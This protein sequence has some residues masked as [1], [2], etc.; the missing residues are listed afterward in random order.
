MPWATYLGRITM[1]P[2]RHT[3]LFTLVLL[4]SLIVAQDDTTALDND[5][6]VTQA[7]VDSVEASYVY[8]TGRTVIADGAATLDLP[9]GYRFLDGDQARQVITDLWENPPEVAAPVIG[10]ILPPN[11]GIWD[12]G[13]TFWVQYD[14]SGYVS[15][16]DAHAMDHA[17]ML[18][19]M[20][21]SDSADNA[22]RIEAGYEP[23]YLIGWAAPPYYDGERKAIH[24]ALEYER[25]DVEE[26]TLNYYVRILGRKG[27]LELNAVGSMSQLE[28]VKE[29]IPSVLGI[30]SFNDGYRYDQFDP[31]TDRTAGRTVGGLVDGRMNEKIAEM[32]GLIGK[33]AL[34]AVGLMLVIAVVVIWLLVRRSRRDRV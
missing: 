14:E 21:A 13:F 10:I 18:T 30:V 27:V 24:W 3:F 33:I 23:L 5:E 7:Y 9:E 6:G 20:L 19:S 2:M 32:A 8:A 4:P 31:A 26:H 17:S 12:E 34:A 28:A 22:L 1:P 29:A 25:E 15:D 16:A 11:T